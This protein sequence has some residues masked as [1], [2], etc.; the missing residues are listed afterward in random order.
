[1][2]DT[3]AVLTKTSPQKLRDNGYTGS[4]TL[5]PERARN[6]DYVV[7]VRNAPGEP[8]D[9]H[10]FLV[11]KITKVVDSPMTKGRYRIL[12]EQVAEIDVPIERKWRNPVFYTSSS[13]LGI[14]ASELKFSRAK[15]RARVK[16][17]QSDG[18][19]IASAKEALATF[20]DISVDNIEIVIRG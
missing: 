11:G 5:D 6:R 13:F 3:V 15:P 20:Y 2:G 12:F 4:W 9:R 7:C 10:A 19:D 1:M 16:E 17:R 14:D 18:L 8:D